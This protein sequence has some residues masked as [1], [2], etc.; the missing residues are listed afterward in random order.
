M[1]VPSGRYR[2][3]RTIYVWPGVR[4]IGYGATR[5]VYAARGQA[6]PDF[7]KGSRRHGDVRRPRARVRWDSACG[8]RIP[9]PPPGSVPPNATDCGRQAEHVLF[10]DEQYRFRNWRRKRGGSCHPISRRAAR[11]SEPHGLSCW[12]GSGRAHADW[13]RSRGSAF[14]RRTLRHPHEKTSPAW[15]FTLI[16]SV[17]EGQR[18]A[19]IRE[20]EA[21]LDT[22]SRYISQCADC[23]RDRSKDIPDQVMGEG[24]P[25]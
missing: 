17:F 1:F 20:H 21:G 14:L 22:D 24:L 12:F 19:A 13:Q 5:P 3:T 18:E 2:M 11:V 16:D 4:V 23:D 9:F 6:R 8:S 10:G 7:R 25:L 15:Q